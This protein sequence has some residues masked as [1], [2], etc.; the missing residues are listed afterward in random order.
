MSYLRLVPQNQ[1][2]DHEYGYSHRIVDFIQY[3]ATINNGKKS[4]NNNPPTNTKQQPCICE[5][6][7]KS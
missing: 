1:I 3:L 4:N 6:K 2:Y 7:D 5:L